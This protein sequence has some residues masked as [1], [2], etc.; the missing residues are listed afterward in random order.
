M[1]TN[2]SEFVGQVLLL[3][4]PSPI[5]LTSRKGVGDPKD[6]RL[7]TNSLAQVFIVS[8]RDSRSHR[9]LLVSH[10]WQK[11]IQGILG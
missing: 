7:G 10:A 6:A 4:V 2:F 5:Q 3:P 1:V 9:V 8:S 11:T